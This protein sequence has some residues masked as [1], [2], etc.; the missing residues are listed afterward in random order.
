MTDFTGP[1]R[2]RSVDSDVTAFQVEPGGDVECSGRMRSGASPLTIGN[3]LLAASVTVDTQTHTAAASA[4]TLPTGSHLMDIY[5]HRISDQF[6]TGASDISIRVG[7]SADDNQF[8]EFH[9]SGA[10]PSWSSILSHEVAATVGFLGV[11]SGA[12]A[13]GLAAANARVF[14]KTTAISG[15]V[16]AKQSLLTVTYQRRA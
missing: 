5:L 15:T 8:G 13:H 4:F 10:T 2:V 3:V 14:V 11:A 7:T 1:L 6:C 16:T 12:G 9:V